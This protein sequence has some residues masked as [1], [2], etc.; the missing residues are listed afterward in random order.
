MDS[1]C[2]SGIKGLENRTKQ[3][4]VDTPATDLCSF[5][6]AALPLSFAL[7]RRRNGIFCEVCFGPAAPIIEIRRLVGGEGG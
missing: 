7:W 1:G 5:G 2:E 3:R 4:N 6:F